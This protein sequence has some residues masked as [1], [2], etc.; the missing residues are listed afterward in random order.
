MKE[1]LVSGGLVALIDDKDFAL[2]QGYSWNA[3][4]GKNTT[5]A[6]AWVRGTYSPQK[7][8]YL[9]RL[10]LN[11]PKGIQVDHQNG[12]GLDCQRANIR[13]ASNGQN[14]CNARKHRIVH[15]NPPLSK[16]KGVSWQK[17]MNTWRARVYVAHHEVMLGYFDSET[18]AALAYNE[19]AVRLYGQFARLNDIMAE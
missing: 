2:V 18:A 6:K 9:H 19:A 15:G 8:I 4:P 5:Y 1:I 12:D 11:A 3:C 17:T 13:L 16:F 7:N 10:I 14:T